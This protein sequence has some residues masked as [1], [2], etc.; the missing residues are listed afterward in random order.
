MK[1]YLRALALALPLSATCFATTVAVTLES[2]N[3]AN[4]G[5]DYVLPYEL[6]INGALTPADCYDFFHD[7]YVGET[8]TADVLT[9][10]EAITHGQFSQRTNAASGYR[11]IAVLRSFTFATTAEQI[12]IQHVMWN[13]F[14]GQLP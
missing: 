6:S 10:D 9:L 8:W 2:V 4:D 14:G 7:V 11:E 1:H 13:V 5:S 12:A 3:G